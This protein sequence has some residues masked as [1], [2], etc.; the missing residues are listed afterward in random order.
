MVW[1]ACVVAPVDRRTIADNPNVTVL[2]KTKLPCPF[3]VRFLLSASGRRKPQHKVQFPEI[4]VKR[5]CERE[6]RHQKIKLPQII[7]VTAATRSSTIISSVGTELGY[8]D[9]KMQENDFK[10]LSTVRKLQKRHRMRL[11][12][13]QIARKQQAIRAPEVLLFI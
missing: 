8:M 2:H 3:R 11:A 7:P 4:P 5:F 1:S 13:E 12:I 6:L 10:M 9:R